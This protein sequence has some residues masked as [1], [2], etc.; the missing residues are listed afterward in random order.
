MGQDCER[1]ALKKPEGSIAEA[2]QVGAAAATLASE[3]QLLNVML[4]VKSEPAAKR[5]KLN[6]EFKLCDSH[7]KLFGVD[8]SRGCRHAFWQK[9]CSQC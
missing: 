8:V 2:L 3:G 6:K 5:Q 7:T 9:Q 4:D 1:F